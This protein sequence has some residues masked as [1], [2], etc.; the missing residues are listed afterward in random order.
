M[1]L[2]VSLACR[3]ALIESHLQNNHCVSLATYSFLYGLR[4]TMVIVN[5]VEFKVGKICTSVL[6][7][8][9]MGEFSYDG[10]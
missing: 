7:H 10:M 1:L 5:V 2:D 6:C 4:N 9:G 3:F 8:N